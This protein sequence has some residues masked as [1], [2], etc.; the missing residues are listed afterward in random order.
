M[1]DLVRHYIALKPSNVLAKYLPAL[2]S[3]NNSASH[4]GLGT[5][6]VN[7]WAT[8]AADPV[9]QQAQNDERDRVYFDR[10]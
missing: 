9:F 1:L 7:D 6:F 3:V 8:A 2:V 4:T 5:P 10:R